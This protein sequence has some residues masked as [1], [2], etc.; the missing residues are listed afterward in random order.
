MTGLGRLVCRRDV[1]SP[2]PDHP[3]C[4]TETTTGR[5]RSK[6]GPEPDLGDGGKVIVVPVRLVERSQRVKRPDFLRSRSELETDVTSTLT[7]PHLRLHKPRT[8][9]SVPGVSTLKGFVSFLRR[10]HGPSFP[11][12]FTTHLRYIR[13]LCRSFFPR[14]SHPYSTN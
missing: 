10:C 4:G 11:I 9:P 8:N 14:V 1:C 13:T 3:W 6:R 2:R 12:P 7:V 5:S